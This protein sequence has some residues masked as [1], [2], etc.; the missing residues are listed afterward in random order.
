MHKSSLPLIGLNSTCLC[1]V[2][3]MAVFLVVCLS[4]WLS[5]NAP[6]VPAFVQTF[7]CC[8]FLVPTLC[9]F[10]LCW[11]CCYY[12]SWA[13]LG[14][15]SRHTYIQLLA[16]WFPPS[17]CNWIRA[18]AYHKHKVVAFHSW[19]GT[20]QNPFAVAIRNMILTWRVGSSKLTIELHK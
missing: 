15:F 10:C 4:R 8:S 14:G 17:C 20:L 12:G 16:P 1:S 11:C 19:F 13:S 2:A 9:C 18:Y 3:R 7:V 6:V 5:D